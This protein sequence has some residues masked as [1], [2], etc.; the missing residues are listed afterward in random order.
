MWPQDA[1]PALQDCFECTQWSIFT[2]AASSG[3]SIDLQE[4]A[5]VVIGFIS[6]G[7]DDVT[8]VKTVKTRVTKEPWLTDE[9]RSLLKTRDSAFKAGD[10][11]AYR[12]ARNNLKRGIRDAKKQDGRN[13]EKNIEDLRASCTNGA[14][15]T[16]FF[17]S[18]F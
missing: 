8:V 17:M 4:Y 3:Y 10:T 9:V 14:W 2:E 11:V 18:T 15:C 7:V 16:H 13:F 1:L 12:E 6:K 5:E